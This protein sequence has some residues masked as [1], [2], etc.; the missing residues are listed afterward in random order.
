MKT[1]F[2]TGV[3]SGIGQAIAYHFLQIGWRV[4]GTV[5]RQEDANAL[6]AHGGDNFKPLVLDITDE[7]AVSELHDAIKLAIG[8]RPLDVICNN[9]GTSVPA[10][11]MDQSVNSFRAAIE[12][13]LIAPFAV[14]KACFPVLKQPGG[15]IVFVGSLAGVHSLPFAAAYSAAKHGIEALAASLRVELS[16][17]GIDTIVIAPGSVRTAIGEKIGTGQQLE[18][19]NGEFSEKFQNMGAHMAKEAATALEPERIAALVEKAVLSP[20]PKPRYVGAPNPVQDWILPKILPLS[21]RDNLWK[22]RLKS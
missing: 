15:R 2:I 4:V 11:T 3:S 1:I 22:R 10:A 14:T 18:G 20:N 12:L 9:A 6:A 21:W 5:R 17:N 19:V 7:R 13:N 16:D 8:E